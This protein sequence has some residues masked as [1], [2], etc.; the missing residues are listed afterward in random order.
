MILLLLGC[1]PLL[2]NALVLG[3]E[4]AAAVVLGEAGAGLG[5]ALAF[6]EDQLA[7]GAPGLG[8]VVVVDLEGVELWRA[9][10]AVPM[11]QRVFAEGLEV[12]AWEPGVGV[13]ALEEGGTREL[14]AQLPTATDVDRCPGGTWVGVDG[15]GSQVSC[16]TGGEATVRCM[17][18]SCA[19]EL[20]EVL[21]GE[22][23]P[24]GGLAWVGDALCWG[25]AQLE[26]DPQSGAVRCADGTEL[27]GEEG[28]HLGVAIAGSS[29]DGARVAGV[30]NKWVVPARARIPSLSGGTTWLVD[31]APE[32]SRLAL[33]ESGGDWAVGVPG[34]G[35]GQA[36]DGKVFIVPAAS[37]DATG[38]QP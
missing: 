26:D 3:D 29:L 28:D 21:L 18:P 20:S 32:R 17:G 22:T 31:V 8:Q 1:G 7:I 36:G 35:S 15:E 25:D 11:G 14:V 16:G 37:A 2:P 27:W 34:F 13:W 30:F 19:V 5:T 9:A 33:A 6:G 23:T 4:I 24:Q 38:A 12:W 10:W